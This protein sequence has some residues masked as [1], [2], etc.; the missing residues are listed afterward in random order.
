MKTP[1][2]PVKKVTTE[3][4]NDTKKPK[5]KPLSSK[6]T[7]NWK[8]KLDNEDDDLDMDLENI[9]EFENDSLDDDDD[10]ENF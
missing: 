10:D 5:L 1:K 3:S 4:K 7:K 6:D 8:N 9:D 2:K